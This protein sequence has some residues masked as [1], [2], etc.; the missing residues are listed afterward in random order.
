VTDSRT[1]HSRRPELVAV[2]ASLPPAVAQSEVARFTASRFPNIDA[3]RVQAVFDNTGIQ[4]RHLARPLNWY[5]DRQSPSVRFRIASDLALEHG[6]FAARQAMARADVL[7]D[8]VDTLIFV[9]TT[10]VRSPNLDVS[11]A[12]TLGLRRDVRRV[13][14][15]GMASLGG[16]AALGL[17]MDL[18]LGGDRTV[19]V[20]ASEMNSLTFVPGDQSMESVV[21]MALFSDGAAAAIVR[22]S[23]ADARPSTVTL[24]ARHSTVVPDTLDVMGFDPTDDGL[25]WRLTPDVPDLARTWTR[26]S[27]EE[28]L[29]EVE[30]E[31][32]DVDHA[33]VHPGGTK[34][35]DAVE[36]AVGWEP[37]HLRWSRDVMRD[38]GN[39][40]SVT[41]LLVVQQFLASGPARGRG[42][43]TAMGPGFAFEHVLFAVGPG[44]A[45]GEERPV[46]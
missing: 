26:A 41:V 3:A 28:A 22:A 46:P 15:F 29:A 7:P 23:V 43:L 21:T 34:V 20:I 25:Q 37:G 9:S 42:L 1:T 11:L 17:A 12:A 44:F 36:R 35:L 33:L 8:D 31:L 45:P 6:S 19:L 14:I 18:V 4:Q 2:A 39:L 13:P 40:S 5:A 38:H 27:V 30:W 16:A 10:V 32:D 24:L